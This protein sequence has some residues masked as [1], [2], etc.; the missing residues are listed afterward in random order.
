[1]QAFGLN[2]M[3]T[4]MLCCAPLDGSATASF[5]ELACTKQTM[6]GAYW[7]IALHVVDFLCGPRVTSAGQSDRG[8]GL[9]TLDCETE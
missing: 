1:M 9:H 7:T 4:T 2:P 3:E 8:L 6:R 5:P